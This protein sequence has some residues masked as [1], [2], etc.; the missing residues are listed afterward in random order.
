VDHVR[1]RST[2]DRSWTVAPSS[3][4]LSLQL[5]RCARVLAKGRERGC[6][7]PVSGLTEGRVAARRP[8]DGGEGSGGESSGAGSL[9]AHNWVNEEWEEGMPRCRFI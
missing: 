5:L 1:L 8:R 6:G 7:G 2:V 3:L 9:R 4:E